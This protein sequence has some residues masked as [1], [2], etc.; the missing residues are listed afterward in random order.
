M[1]T[2][3]LLKL[4]EKQEERENQKENSKWHIFLKLKTHIS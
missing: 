1:A 4:L 3:V 2:R